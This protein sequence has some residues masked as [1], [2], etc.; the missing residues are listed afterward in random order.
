MPNITLLSR[1]RHT[2][3]TLLS[4]FCHAFVTL[5]SRFCH[6]FVTLLSRFCHAYVTLTSRLRHAFV[7]LL[8][9]FCHTFVTLSSLLITQLPFRLPPTRIR[10][11]FIVNFCILRY[12]NPLLTERTSDN[13]LMVKEG[14]PRNS[15]KIFS[16]RETFAA[17][18]LIGGGVSIMDEICISIGLKVTQISC[19]MQSN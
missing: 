10:I 3:V 1:F 12:T 5:L 11:F 6:A 2:F 17:L 8:S 19:P 16:S 15:F 9:H 13:S 18:M 4:H 7:T 14:F